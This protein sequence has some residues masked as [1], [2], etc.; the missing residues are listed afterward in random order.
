MP[1]VREAYKHLRLP[2]IDDAYENLHILTVQMARSGKKVMQFLSACRYVVN[3][4]DGKV[5]LYK[6]EPRPGSREV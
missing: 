3:V 6:E 1:T 4:V 2:V 5:T